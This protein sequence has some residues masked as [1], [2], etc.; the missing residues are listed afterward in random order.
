MAQRKMRGNLRFHDDEWAKAHERK[1]EA[2]FGKMPFLR[3]IR[4][5]SLGTLPDR[6]DQVPGASQG[7]LQMLRTN[8][9]RAVAEVG[10]W[11]KIAVE[12]G[13]PESTS[14]ERTIEELRSRLRS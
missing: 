11:R 13:L 8:K 14:P 7:Y 1:K 5:L 6:T 4:E 12:L 3:W 9:D 10:R 2:G